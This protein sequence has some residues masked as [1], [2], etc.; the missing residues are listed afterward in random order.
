MRALPAPPGCAQKT[1]KNVG[2]EGE[3]RTH[4]PTSPLGRRQTTQG[5]GPRPRRPCPCLSALRSGP[6]PLRTLGP[7]RF[8]GSP[9]PAPVPG[10][11]SSS[12]SGT[13]GSGE[14]FA[15]RTPRGWASMAGR[16]SGRRLRADGAGG[17]ER[18]RTIRS[19]R[20][21]GGDRPARPGAQRSRPSRS[22]TRT[23]RAEPRRPH[24]QPRRGPA[25]PRAASNPREVL[26]EGGP[27][28]ASALC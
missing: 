18:S 6:Q 21:G 4:P 23:R 1:L 28:G 9:W 5:A 25:R 13:A 11:S 14:S 17:A 22:R 20:G 16:P 8:S 3:T 15:E 12:S 19:R 7:A 2:V 10:S 24:P 27:A 26:L